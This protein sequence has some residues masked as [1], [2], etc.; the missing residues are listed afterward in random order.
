MNSGDILSIY[1]GDLNPFSK[2]N[3]SLH[4][5]HFENQLF[6]FLINIISF[7]TQIF[8]FCFLKYNGLDP[9]LASHELKALMFW[10]F[11]HPL[12]FHGLFLWVLQPSE[13]YFQQTWGIAVGKRF[14]CITVTGLQL[15]ISDNVLWLDQSIMKLCRDMIVLIKW[16]SF[17]IE[18]LCS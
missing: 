7:S 5:S 14:L 4:Y 8:E 18:E 11:P 15:R 12:H 17:G 6:I 3:F 2:K 1:E 10:Q 13:V 9:N 16:D